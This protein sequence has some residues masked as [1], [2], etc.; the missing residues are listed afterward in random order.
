MATTEYHPG[1]NASPGI[2]TQA[3][4]IDRLKRRLGDYQRHGQAKSTQYD[5]WSKN[6]Y[7]QESDQTVAL[8]S[9]W[10]EQRNVAA[11]RKPAPRK[12]PNSDHKVGYFN[13]SLHFPA[14]MF[15]FFH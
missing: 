4:T 2:A 9:K 10:M 1:L 6:Q 15:A 11:Q 5:N 13:V 12:E 8:H 3:E 14:F 7:S